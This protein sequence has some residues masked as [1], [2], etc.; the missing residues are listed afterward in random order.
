[1]TVTIKVPM[2]PE[3]TLRHVKKILEPHG[4]TIDVHEQPVEGDRFPSW[5]LHLPEGTK[6]EKDG[7]TGA[8]HE[9]YRYTLPDGF[10]FFKRLMPMVGVLSAFT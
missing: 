6:Q 7:L 5:L 8:Y 3:T 2:L 4:V 9:H 1:M 10:I